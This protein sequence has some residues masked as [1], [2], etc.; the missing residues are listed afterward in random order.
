MKKKW[1]EIPG[2]SRDAEKK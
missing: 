2:K 1:K